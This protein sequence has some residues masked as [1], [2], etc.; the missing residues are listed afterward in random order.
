MKN[1]SPMSP[2]LV[3]VGQSHI[4]QGC[5]SYVYILIHTLYTHICKYRTQTYM[6]TLSHIHSVTHTQPHTHTHSHT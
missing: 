5:W 3:S 1:N 6:Y 4:C 2:Y